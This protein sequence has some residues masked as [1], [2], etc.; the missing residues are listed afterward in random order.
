MEDPWVSMGGA[1]QQGTMLSSLSG[2][3]VTLLTLA[4]SVSSGPV[5]AIL[6]GNLRG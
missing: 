5:K 2:V 4:L 6:M 3:L 1:K